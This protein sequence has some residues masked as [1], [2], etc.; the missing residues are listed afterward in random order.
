MNHMEAI[1]IKIPGDLAKHLHFNKM[2]LMH[3][4]G[5]LVKDKN[6]LVG[7]CGQGLWALPSVHLKEALLP[8]PQS[9]RLS[10]V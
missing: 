8:A 5:T 2:T 10:K 4:P 6:R 7:S 9:R 1:K 3:E